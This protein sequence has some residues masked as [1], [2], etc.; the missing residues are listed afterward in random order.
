MMS[1]IYFVA[2]HRRDGE[3][4]VLGDTRL[5]FHF[6]FYGCLEAK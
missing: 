1:V 5:A 2:G 3:G 4:C 6:D